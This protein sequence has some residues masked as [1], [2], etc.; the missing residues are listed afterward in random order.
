[1]LTQHRLQLATHLYT[2]HLLDEDHFLDWI[3]NGL[4]TCPSE[5]LFVWLLVISV[6]HYWKDITCCRRRGKRL[7]ESLL[8][9]LEKVCKVLLRLA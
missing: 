6:S 1:M 7:A 4:D 2:E 9:Q 5:R 3:V 8:N